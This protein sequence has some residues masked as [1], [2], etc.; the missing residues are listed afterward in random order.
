MG[1]RAVIAQAGKSV[2]IYLH[3]NGGRDSVEAFLEYC[4]LKGYPG[5]NTSY[6]VARLCQVIS[7]FFGGD[8]SVGIVTDINYNDAIGLDNGIYIVSGWDITSRIP[9]NV[10]EQH[11]H[12]RHEM[13]LCIDKSMP[14]EEQLGEE[15]LNASI[16]PTSEIKIGDMVFVRDELKCTVDQFEVVGIGEDRWVNGHQVLG[17]PYVKRFGYCGDYSEN[18]NNYLFD[19]EYRMIKEEKE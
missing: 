14:I 2:G 9:E 1:N 4:K 19:A 7:N 6:G 13:L 11:S 3:W 5:F 16:V 8:S 15:F 17:V 10:Y 12:D 18:P